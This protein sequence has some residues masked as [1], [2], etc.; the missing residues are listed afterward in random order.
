MFLGLLANA[1]PGAKP[2][3]PNDA[4]RIHHQKKDG[5]RALRSPGSYDADFTST[6][7]LVKRPIRELLKIRHFSFCVSWNSI[8]KS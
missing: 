1:F 2:A 6:D 8:Y 7:R 4:F 5:K 3:Y